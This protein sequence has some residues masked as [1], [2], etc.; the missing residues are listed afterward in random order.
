[1]METLSDKIVRR[2]IK[3]K[4][5][6]DI[7]VNIGYQRAILVREVKE[8]IKKLKEKVKYSCSVCDVM[9]AIHELAGDKLI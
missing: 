2:A 9:E 6:E 4:E 5:T 1:M 3:T 7:F 8:F